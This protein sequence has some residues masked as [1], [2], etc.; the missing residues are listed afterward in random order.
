MIQSRGLFAPDS[1]FYSGIPELQ[2]DPAEAARLVEEL[3][4][5][6]WDGKVRLHMP[7]PNPD[8]PIAIEASLE[9]VGMDV[10]LLVTDT[11]TQIT[12]I[13]VDRNYDMGGW[14]WNISDSSF[15]QNLTVTLG[16]S[17]SAMGTAEGNRIGFINSE[18]DQA[19]L[20]LFAAPDLAARQAVAKRLAEIFAEEV[21]SVTYGAIEE[22]YVYSPKV[23]GIQATQQSV[24]LLHKAYL[25]D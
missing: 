12:A 7:D 5:E 22:G 8:L 21:P 19:I 13:A 3:K 20:D 10:D 6:G 16:R 9:A 14:G 15:Y 18:V 11:T 25:A 24:I 4:S 17:P 1:I 2:P 23:R